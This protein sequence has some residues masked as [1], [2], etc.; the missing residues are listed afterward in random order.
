MNVER[1]SAIQKSDAPAESIY[2]DAPQTRFIGGVRGQDA[3]VRHGH[4]L[5]NDL[6]TEQAMADDGHWISE[7]LRVR[8]S[9]GPTR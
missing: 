2:H 9:S 3:R 7:R 6:G 8:K 4:D 1:V 5:L